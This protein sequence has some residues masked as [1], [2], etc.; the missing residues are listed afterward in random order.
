MG[1]A[2][3][4]ILTTATANDHRPSE[5]IRSASSDSLPEIAM[6]YQPHKPP[7]TFKFPEMVSKNVSD[8]G[9]IFCEE[10]E[11]RRLI[12]GQFQICKKGLIS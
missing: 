11:T 6:T 1:A 12:F 9:N 2:T 10:R 7:E 3:A 4:A 5:E 8:I